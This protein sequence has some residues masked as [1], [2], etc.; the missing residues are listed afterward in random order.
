[1]SPHRL[2]GPG[3][4]WENPWAS[5]SPAGN[6]VSTPSRT[7]G[8]SRLGISIPGPANGCGPS[9]AGIP[10]LFSPPCSS[11]PHRYTRIKS[12]SAIYGL[13]AIGSRSHLEEGGAG[14]SIVEAQLAVPP[15]SLA[16]A[17]LVE[18]ALEGRIRERGHRMLAAFK[19]LVDQ[20]PS[21]VA[22]VGADAT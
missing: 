2:A 4:C 21:Q 12:L 20:T 8:F 7:S 11:P 3:E 19:P 15:P 6:L 13:P 14:K 9:E 17:W 5:V 1:R 16:M 10:G 18:P 22:R